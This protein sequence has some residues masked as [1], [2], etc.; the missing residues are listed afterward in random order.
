MQDARDL[1]VEMNHTEDAVGDDSHLLPRG[2]VV[3]R[4]SGEPR[5]CYKGVILVHV[6][7]YRSGGCFGF[8]SNLGVLSGWNI[9]FH[10]SAA[11]TI[12]SGDE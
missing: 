11:C 6:F 3:T 8:P 12:G 10:E 1:G 2:R 7:Y 9:V 4:Q 5:E